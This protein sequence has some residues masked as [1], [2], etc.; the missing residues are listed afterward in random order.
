M[1]QISIKSVYNLESI[2]RG[3]WLSSR[4][5]YGAISKTIRTLALFASPLETPYLINGYKLG[6]DSAGLPSS[7]YEY[8]RIQLGNEILGQRTLWRYGR[9]SILKAKQKSQGN[10]L[11]GHTEKTYMHVMAFDFMS[12]RKFKAF[13][14]KH[15]IAFFIVII[16]RNM[17]TA[18]C[19]WRW[20]HNHPYF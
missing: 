18:I 1:Q 6:P 14:N 19:G 9:L 11:L 7:S 5:F 3:T 20:Q 15:C 17:G 10:Q 8:E 2:R 12:H 16:G 13:F 4:P